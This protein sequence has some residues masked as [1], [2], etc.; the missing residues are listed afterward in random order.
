MRILEFVQREQCRL[1]LHLAY[2]FVQCNQH[3]YES[4]KDIESHLFADPHV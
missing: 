4:L 1:R 2:V 3:V